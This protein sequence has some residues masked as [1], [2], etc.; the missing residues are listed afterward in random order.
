ME[1]SP[2]IFFL[3]LIIG[4]MILLRVRRH[5]ANKAAHSILQDNF[6]DKFTFRKTNVKADIFTIGAAKN[7]EFRFSNCNVCTLP[8]AIVLFGFNDIFY[9]SYT[10]PIILTANTSAYEDLSAQAK[11]V[12]PKKFNLNS[13]G[14]VYIEFGEPGWQTVKVEMRLKG[15]TDSEKEH[16][17]LF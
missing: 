8:D 15:L 4:L 16:L 6:N 13:F 5:K 1:Y 2:A 17:N 11:V 12:Q 10:I 14:D 7:T 9:K 3:L